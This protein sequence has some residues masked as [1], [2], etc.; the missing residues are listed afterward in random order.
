MKKILTIQGGGLKGIIPATVLANFEDKVGRKCCNIFDLI[1]GTSTGA[2]IGGILASGV[3]SALDIKNLYINDGK[4]LFTPRIP[5]A[6]FLGYLIGSKYNRK[7]FIDK[8]TELTDNKVL[9]D[10]ATEFMATTFNLC[11]GRTH[12][13]YSTDP[14][15]K[16]YKLW[17]IISWSA[18]SA[19]GY[20]DKISAPDFLWDDFKS[21]GTI[22]EDIKGGVFQDG[23]QGINNCTLGA[24]IAA[25]VARKWDNE[26]IIILSLGC[27]NYHKRSSFKKS[28]KT[29][30]A[31]QVV[32]FFSEAR[33]E[34]SIM[35][36]MEAKLLSNRRPENFTLVHIDCLI[37]EKL[38]ILDGV[39]YIK[40][41]ENYGNQ[42]KNSIPFELFK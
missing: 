2:I 35:Q 13:I 20:F 5:F 31:G 1:T 26:K 19:A 32:K 10:V 22:E 28:S 34:A 41:Y 33:N 9:G 27:G 12:F 3:K 6:P 25:A 11:S 17:E 38:D 18:L 4:K 24:V 7:L 29:G 42:L 37:P 30:V 40:D 23:G 14:Y 15:E 8:I 21:D 16:I 39:R 36:I